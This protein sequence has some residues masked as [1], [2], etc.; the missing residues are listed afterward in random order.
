MG[1]VGGSWEWIV[2][3]HDRV[4]GRKALGLETKINSCWLNKTDQ[5]VRF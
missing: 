3:A 4:G 5:N 2:N 1:M